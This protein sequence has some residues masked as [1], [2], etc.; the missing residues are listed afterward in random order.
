MTFKVEN[1]L[2]TGLANVAN[3]GIKNTIYDITQIKDIIKN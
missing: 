1:K 3:D 2:Y